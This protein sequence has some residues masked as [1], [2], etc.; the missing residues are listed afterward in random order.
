[1]SNKSDYDVIIIGA[2]ISGLVCGCYLAKEGLKALIVEKNAK[3]GGY[4][5][6]FS[7]KGFHFDTFVHSLGSCR[8]DGNVARVLRE[9]DI[10]KKIILQKVNPS[11][12][13]I[14]PDYRVSF[15]SGLNKTICNFQQNFPKESSNIESFFRDVVNLQGADLVKLKNNS[16][17]YFLKKYFNDK[18]LQ[19]ILSFPILGNNGLSAS[20]ISAFSGCKLYKEF[21]LDGGYVV[22]GGMQVL[23]DMLAA[24]FESFGG[25]LVL[26][27]Y[28]KKINVNFNKAEGVTLNNKDFISSRYVVSS[29]DAMKTFFKF[30]GK[31]HVQRNFLK[32]LSNMVPSLSMFMV[33][34]GFNKDLPILPQKG[35]N[36]WYLPSYDV[37]KLYKAAISR[38]KNN[39]S[40]FMIHSFS[41]R[42]I[43]IFMNAHFGGKKYWDYCKNKVA[44]RLI[45]K[46]EKL[47]PNL[48]KH[49]IYKNVITP[50]ALYRVTAN[51]RGAAYGWAGLPSQLAE[52]GLA[53]RTCIDN[54]YLTGHWTSLGQGVGGVTYLG[55]DTANL[56][57]KNTKNK[58]K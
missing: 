13:I 53:Q 55:R 10:D 27:N 38:N 14:T 57:I 25:V 2:G 3:P 16:F 22:K 42:N 50:Y 19:A 52:P 6:S 12:T 11:D 51:Y 29:I 48:S 28:V 15:Y 30:L 40:E 46:V 54:L 18:K 21:M 8:K 58:K 5:T 20:L 34:L 37:N 47:V 32:R 1:M 9:L 17:D 7:R 33:Y 24:R 26:T 44:D 23:S 31:E 45:N 35:T 4:C 43:S 41:K 36:T 39:V 49:I 56:I